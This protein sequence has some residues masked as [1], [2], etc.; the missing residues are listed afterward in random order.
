MAPLVRRENIDLQSRKIREIA[1]ALL[2]A[3]Y[4]CLDDQAE[5]LGLA[6]STTWT[7]LH[8]RHKNT[9]LS[10]SVIKQILAQPQLPK[11]VRRKVVEYVQQ[12]SSGMYGHNS[13]RVRRF[14]SGLWGLEVD[15]R[16]FPPV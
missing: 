15:A 14:A 16:A 3:G 4:L 1:E 7:I 10:A 13:K 2:T 12:K 8:A 11:L 5:V 6:R 9:G